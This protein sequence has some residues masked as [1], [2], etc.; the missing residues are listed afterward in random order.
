MKAPN[1]DLLVKKFRLPDTQAIALMGSFAR[2]EAG[3]FSDVDLIRFI[4]LEGV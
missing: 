2:G 3:E 4:P 1:F